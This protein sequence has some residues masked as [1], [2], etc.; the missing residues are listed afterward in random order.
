MKRI[1]PAAIF[2]ATSLVVFAVSFSLAQEGVR[3][4]SVIGMHGKAEVMAQGSTVWTEVTDKTR[5]GAG[6]TIRTMQGSYVDLD[7]AGK[8][9][10]AVTRVNE[11]TT[12]K[13][14]TYVSSENIE[15]RRIILDLA[16]GDVLVKV[17]K[18]K[19]ESQFQVRT[20]MSIVGVRGT[21]F[22]VSTSE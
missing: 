14:D 17:N 5:L 21:M 22:R 3:D 10:A 15:E 12:L 16:V 6:D 13:I 4:V 20:P 11:K 18:I 9:Q 8:A 19:N 7:F 1:I 2:I